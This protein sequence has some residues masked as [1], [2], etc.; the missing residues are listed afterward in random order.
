[1]KVLIDKSFEKDVDKIDD[2]R[3]LNRIA[4]KI[5][6]IRQARKLSEITNC[7]KIRNSR[8]AYR[9]KIGDYRAGF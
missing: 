8:T 1:M 2:K 4:D 6:A 5:E 3:L 9:I 7:K